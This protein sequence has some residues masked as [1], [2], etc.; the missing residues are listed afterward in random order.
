MEN[1]ESKSKNNNRENKERRI[2]IIWNKNIEKKNRRRKKDV[3]TEVWCG[4]K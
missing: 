1:N 2:N 4:L 3:K